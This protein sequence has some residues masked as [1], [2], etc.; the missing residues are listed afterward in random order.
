MSTRPNIP[1]NYFRLL[2]PGGSQVAGLFGAV[3]RRTSGGVALRSRLRRDRCVSAVPE[4]STVDLRQL[5]SDDCA[6]S[7]LQNGMSWI[8]A[9]QSVRRAN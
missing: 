8:D 4:H 6:L 3:K 1:R 7:A 2:G 5:V 9:T